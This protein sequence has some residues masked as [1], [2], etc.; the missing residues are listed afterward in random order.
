[1]AIELVAAYDFPKEVR[2]LFT[3]YTTMLTNS[4]PSLP[5]HLQQQA[6]PESDLLYGYSGRLH[7]QEPV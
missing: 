4:D 5:H 6:F 3:E 1:M 7:P 2:V